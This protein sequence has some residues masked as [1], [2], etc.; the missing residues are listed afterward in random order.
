MRVIC[1]SQPPKSAL[2]EPTPGCAA[3]RLGRMSAQLLCAL[4]KLEQARDI[5]QEQFETI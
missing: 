4:L 2:R 3:G 1:Q 5:S